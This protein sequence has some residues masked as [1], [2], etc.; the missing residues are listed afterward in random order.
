MLKNTLYAHFCA[1]ENRAEIKETLKKLKALRYDGVILE[2]AL[3]ILDPNSKE[4][5][6]SDAEPAAE[7]QNSHEAIDTWKRGMLETLDMVEP[8]NFVGLKS[9]TFS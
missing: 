5:G 8:G 9:V 6:N 1:G 4:G 2:Y 3:E 7:T